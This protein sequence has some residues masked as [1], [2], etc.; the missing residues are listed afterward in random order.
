MGSDPDQLSSTCF[1]VKS[2]LEA[3]GAEHKSSSVTNLTTNGMDTSR[4]YGRMKAHYT[5]KR[6]ADRGTPLE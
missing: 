6:Y 1:A 2:D 5:L 4:T 3:S